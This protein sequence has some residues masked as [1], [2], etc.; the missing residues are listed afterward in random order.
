MQQIALHHDRGA[1]APGAVA[2]DSTGEFLVITADV[3]L[4]DPVRAD[5]VG[6]RFDFI[7]L[8]RD[9]D[10]SAGIAAARLHHDALG[11]LHQ[12]RSACPVVGANGGRMTQL[13]A[14]EPLGRQPLVVAAFDALGVADQHHR[15]RVGF[16]LVPKPGKMDRFGVRSH[17]D[18]IDLLFGDD[19]AQGVAECV[20][21][22]ARD[23]IAPVY[24]VQTG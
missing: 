13:F 6:G 3:F 20:M 14:R 23:R 22:R 1:D 19:R 18:E 2:Q 15:P 10:A 11:G 21:I 12:R 24:R 4:D 8:C 17:Q 7:A 9:D 5:P 16:D